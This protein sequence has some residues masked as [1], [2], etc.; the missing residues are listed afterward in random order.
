[1]GYLL[2]RLD[3]ADKLTSISQMHGK[4]FIGKWS[5]KEISL[6]T[7]YHPA[8]ALYNGSM[9]EVLFKDAEVLKQFIN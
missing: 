8:V 1:M 7:L 6:V 9:R 2:P 4:L 3:L 5:G